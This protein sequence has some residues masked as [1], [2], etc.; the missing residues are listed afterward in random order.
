MQRKS[1]TF[2]LAAA[3]VAAAGCLS[4]VS[5]GH[6]ASPAK[7]ST[8]FIEICHGYECT[9]RSKLRL[10]GRDASRFASIMASGRASPEAERSAVGRAIIYFE[11]RTAAMLGKK[12]TPL[13]QFANSRVR[14]E[15]D[16]I[17]EATNSRAL[18]LYL[19]QRGLL[20]YHKV[21][22]NLSRGFI[23]DNQ[24][25]HAAAALR[26]PAGVTWAVDSWPVPVGAAPEIMPASKWRSNGNLGREL[27][28]ALK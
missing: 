22:R 17:D 15:M 7:T 4:D 21:G 8:A 27:D 24:F 12:D 23:L 18:L 11:Q 20:K 5:P 26:D 3:V 10:T 1:I 6:A 14:A 28:A 25:P 9:Y 2:V 19:Q 16:C 13:T